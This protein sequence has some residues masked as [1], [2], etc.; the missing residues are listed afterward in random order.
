[1][2]FA[3]P[4]FAGLNVIEQKLKATPAMTARCDAKIKYLQGQ[5]NKYR[6]YIAAGHSVAI[7]KMKLG[8]FKAELENWK[9]YCVDPENVV[10]QQ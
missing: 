3:T 8:H 5:V 6:N 2:I 9:G 4:S 1:M 10:S 7:N